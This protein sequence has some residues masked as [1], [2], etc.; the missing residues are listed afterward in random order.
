MADAGFPNSVVVQLERI[1]SRPPLA[2]SPSLSRLLRFLV[3][4]SL[5]GREAEINEYNLGVHVFHR[6]E[7]F[8]PRADPIVRVQTHHLRS[9]LARYYVTAGTGDSLIIEIPPRT[10]VPVFRPLE[11]AAPPSSEAAAV[12]VAESPPVAQEQTPKGPAHGTL[13]A[14]GVVLLVAVGAF[15]LLG[16][17]RP[18]DV[19]AKRHEPDAVAQ[20]LYI[21]GRYLLDRETETAIRQS[22]ECFR[23]SVA[24]DPHFAAAFAGLAD[25]NNVLV[26]YGYM[27]PHEGMEEAKRAVK[28]ALALDPD[29]AEAHVSMAA[30]TEA[31]DWDFKAAE[32]EYRR[33]IQLNPQLAA[34]HLWYGMFL[35]DQGRLQEAMPEMRRAEQL[36]PLSVLA[37]L[38]MAHTFIM[39]GDSTAALE[40]AR[41]AVE[42]NPELPNADVLLARIYRSRDD[43]GDADASLAEALRLSAGDAHVLSSLACTYAKLGRRAESANLL[44]E[45]EQLATRRYVSPYD[46]ANVALTL[47]DED[48]AFTWF[49]EAYRERSSGIVFLRNEKEST[50]AHSPR[51]RSLFEKICR[52]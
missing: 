40:R 38:N 16:R 8:N 31:Y 19:R 52:G 29:L 4:E 24:H 12:A 48:R 41:R 47:G 35:R 33:A 22:I 18:S 17:S 5:A 45:M 51:L 14:V 10:Y 42:L 3:E 15:G 50:I 1:L 36:E 13:V 30:I 43:I 21:Q 34:A 11:Q 46:L 28:Q 49:E 6:G 9:R 44:H 23:Q 37:N 27:S 39:A 26:Q 25:A 7:D 32:S 20:D 2:S